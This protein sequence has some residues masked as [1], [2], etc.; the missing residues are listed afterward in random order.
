[1]IFDKLCKRVETKAP[2]LVADVNAARLFVV[3]PTNK[4][5]RE[6]S[7]D[8]FG[9]AGEWFESKQFE[10]SFHEFE[11]RLPYPCMAVSDEQRGAAV[12]M[13]HLDA[14]LFWVLQ[15][16]AGPG[17]REMLIWGPQRVAITGDPSQPDFNWLSL[18][19]ESPLMRWHWPEG[20]AYLLAARTLPCQ[21][22]VRVLNS[23]ARFILEQTPKVVPPVAAR[24]ARRSYQRPTYTVLRPNEIRERMRL[25]SPEVAEQG[26]K[27]APHERRGHWR[28][29]PDDPERFPQV[30]GRR[31]WVKPCWIGPSENSVGRTHY[32]V[33]L[34]EGTA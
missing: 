29:Y 22:L 18:E 11:A 31:V 20:D 13:R 3:E 10:G 28:R 15:Y 2:Q 1:M 24:K 34:E 7:L 4:S 26:R 27:V 12:V 17:P 9:D 19:F 5:V 14:D 8:S 32:R 33:I 16:A 6:D 30:H 23:P 25:P 21:D